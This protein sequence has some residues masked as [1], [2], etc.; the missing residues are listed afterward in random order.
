MKITTLFLLGILGAG[1]LYSPVSAQ[2]SAS[3]SAV[4]TGKPAIET[5]MVELFANT[6]KL[7]QAKATAATIALKGDES[8]PEKAKTSEASGLAIIA[9]LNHGAAILDAEK[10]ACAE[11]GMKHEDF[12][13]VRTRFLQYKML[14]TLEQN[15]EKLVGKTSGNEMGQESTEKLNNELAK[16]EQQLE[17][18]RENLNRA[19]A[20]EAAYYAG[21]DAKIN[22]QKEQISK[23]EAGLATAKNEKQRASKEKQLSAAKQKLAKLEEEKGKPYKALE[24]AKEK[25]TQNEKK[26]AL[27]RENMPAMQA[28]LDKIASDIQNY[29]N[30]MEAG[31]KQTMD[32][33]IMQ[34]AK[35]DA[36]VFAQFPDLKPFLIQPGNESR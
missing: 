28:Q 26:L 22:K 2:S 33:D 1:C 31:I 27:F 21:I 12:Q 9:A 19:Q 32:S 4:I 25:V 16:L 23:L 14:T 7:A 6:M 20:E 10:N 36:A 3:T 15:K 24:N 35:T 34:Q 5:S 13:E 29:Q 18:S 17:K 11:T 30:K 8:S